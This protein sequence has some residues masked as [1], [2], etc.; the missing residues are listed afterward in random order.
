MVGVV[1]LQAAASPPAAANKAAASKVVVNRA[2]VVRVADSKAAAKKEAETRHL[3]NRKPVRL[4]HRE[5][6][7]AEG[8]RLLS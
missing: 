1:D 2:V 3:S 4:P 8:D 7:V 5:K 6:V